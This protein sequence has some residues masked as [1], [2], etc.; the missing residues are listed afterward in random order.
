MTGSWF[1]TPEIV[2][3]LTREVTPSGELSVE[4]YNDVIESAE[5]RAIRD[6]LHPGGE[7][8]SKGLDWVSNGEQ[9][10]AGFVWYLPS[11]FSGFSKSERISVPLLPDFVQELEE[12]NPRSLAARRRGEMGVPKV[13]DKLSYI[14][15]SRARK[16][17]QDAVRLAKEEGAKRYLSARSLTGSANH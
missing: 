6:Q 9:R 10:K 5:R 4:Q 11:R 14:G 13:E 2:K 3:L 17:A 12:S 1:R 8:Q 7:D 16:E 15:E